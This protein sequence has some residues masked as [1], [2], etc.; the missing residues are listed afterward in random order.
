MIPLWL[1][2][3]ACTGITSIIIYGSIFGTV[4]DWLCIKSR[5]LHDLLKC[6]L[7][8]GFWVGLVISIINYHNIYDN[9]LFA[10]ASS[11]VCWLYDSIVGSAQ[12]IEVYYHNKNK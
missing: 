7:C 8:L 10:A 12:S 9:I 11:A 6:S 4:R 1:Q 3:V 5:L 2:L